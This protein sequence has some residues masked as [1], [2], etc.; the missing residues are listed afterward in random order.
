MS[1]ELPSYESEVLIL[2]PASVVMQL[3]RLG[4]FHQS[5]ISFYS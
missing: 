2:R 4:S 5:R 3:P 1:S